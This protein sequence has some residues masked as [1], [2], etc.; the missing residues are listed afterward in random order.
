MSGVGGYRATR[1]V[2]PEAQAVR[3]ESLVVDMGELK[4]SQRRMADALEKLVLLEERQ[5]TTAGALDR[6]FTTIKEQ[7]ARIKALELAQPKQALLSGWVE[8]GILVTL[9]GIGAKFLG[10]L[11]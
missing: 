7:D 3:M 10:L 6:A 4:D 9:G 1:D 11:G 2:S 8:K 5:K